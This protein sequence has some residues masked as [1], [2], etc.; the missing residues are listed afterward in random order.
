MGIVPSEDFS[1][2]CVLVCSG[3]INTGFIHPNYPLFHQ[4]CGLMDFF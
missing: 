4:A 1:F 2:L 3:G